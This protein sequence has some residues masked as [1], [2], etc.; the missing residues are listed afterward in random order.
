MEVTENGVVFGFKSSKNSYLALDVI[1]S[2]GNAVHINS[3]SVVEIDEDNPSISS[4]IEIVAQ[5]LIDSLCHDVSDMVTKQP[6]MVIGE[7]EEQNTHNSDDDVSDAEAMPS[8]TASSMHAEELS[9]VSFEA[10]LAGILPIDPVVARD[11]DAK[12]VSDA[13]D[14]LTA[15]IVGGSKP[16]NSHSL[17]EATQSW[18][19]VVVADWSSLSLSQETV[20]TNFIRSW[21]DQR[22]AGRGAGIEA[23]DIPFGVQL[24]FAIS[25]SLSMTIKV[26]SD[27]SGS[28]RIDRMFVVALLVCVEGEDG[29]HPTEYA[30]QPDPPGVFRQP[31]SS[32]SGDS[33]REEGLNLVLLAARNILHA[34]HSDLNALL[35]EPAAVVCCSEGGGG[36]GEEEMEVIAGDKPILGD[37]SGSNEAVKA[38]FNANGNKKLVLNQAKS[39]D[40]DKTDI[41]SLLKQQQGQRK[42]DIP[43]PSDNVEPPYS[44]KDGEKSVDYLSDNGRLANMDDGDGQNVQPSILS[45]KKAE[46]RDASNTAGS[47]KAPRTSPQQSQPKRQRQRDPRILQKAASVGMK[48]ENFEGKGLEQQALDELQQMMA[49]SE[50]EGFLSVLKS[51][52]QQR[53]NGQ[54]MKEKT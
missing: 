18:T 10:Q 43:V 45:S 53:Q 47:A 34:M 6:S 19:S 2:E 31:S 33:R 41:K 13:I 48:L 3:R 23:S 12:Y 4:L 25:D 20:V 49:N 9:R 37:L 29:N 51:H 35:L 40:F 11:I 15:E 39:E 24:T 44:S 50:G 7:V 36:R 38:V 26:L 16:E 27:Y 28:D 32:T 52:K 8:S 17:L 54:S 22:F 14:G 46:R 21:T 1:R 30:T 42:I 5:N